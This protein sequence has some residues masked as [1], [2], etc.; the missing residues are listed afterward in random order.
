MKT[1]ILFYLP[2]QEEFEIFAVDLDTEAMGI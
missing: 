2:T 1:W